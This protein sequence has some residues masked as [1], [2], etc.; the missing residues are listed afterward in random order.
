VNKNRGFARLYST[1]TELQGEPR[2]SNGPRT[3]KEPHWEHEDGADEPENSVN[4]DSHKAEGQQEK[5]DYWVQHQSEQRER[6]A[7]NDEDDPEEESSH[8][9]LTCGGH[10]ASR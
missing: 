2:C 8:G 10:N 1:V 6:P 5:P 9:N 7:Q 4:R 3:A